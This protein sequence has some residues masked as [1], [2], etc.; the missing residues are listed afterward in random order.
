M[1][2]TLERIELTNVQTTSRK[3]TRLLPP[4][5]KRR[6][7]VVVADETGMVMCFGMKKDQIEQVF[8]TAPLGKEASRVELGGTGEE[9]DNIFMASSGTV[10]AY[11]KK[12]KEFLRFNTNLTEPIRSMWVGEE[13]IHTGGEF[14]YNTFINCKDTYFF[15]SSDRI[16]DIMCDHVS[17]GRSIDAALACQDRMIRVVQGNDLHYE[18]A[19]GGPVLTID[20]YSNAIRDANKPDAFGGFGQ[21][22]QDGPSFAT[23]DGRYRELVYGTENGVV[24]AA[25]PG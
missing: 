11:T 24:G 14:M 2:L 12:G 4:G 23:N 21:Q 1:E 10:R 6:Q 19:M 22:A 9:R 13:D 20:R 25:A 18:A 7:N 17:G 5:K 3:T 15:M 16:N 8:K